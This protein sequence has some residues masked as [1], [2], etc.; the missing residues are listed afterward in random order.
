[1]NSILV[2][3]HTENFPESF[4]EKLSTFTINGGSRHRF[5]IGQW[6][7]AVWKRSETNRLIQLSNAESAERAMTLNLPLL[8][9]ISL[10]T[11]VETSVYRSD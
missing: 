7:A 11:S 2:R 1:M 10:S 5:D 4:I 9:M 8:P 3:R 6:R